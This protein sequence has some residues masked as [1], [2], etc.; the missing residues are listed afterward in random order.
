MFDFV[1][2]L[3]QGGGRLA[4]AFKDGMDI[5][6]VV[7]NLAGIDF[8]RMGFGQYEQLVFESGGTGRD[9]QYGE[10]I[11][12]ERENEFESFLMGRKAFS[13]SKRVLLTVGG[14][15][16]AGTGFMFPVL[17]YLLDRGK[18]VLL[19]YTLPE[20]REGLPTKPNALKS[21][22]RLIRDYINPERISPLLIDN[23]FCV[24]RYGRSVEGGYWGQVNAGIVNSLKRFYMLTQLEKF[25]AFI[26]VSSGYKALDFNDLT[27]MLFSKNGYIDL[28]R[29][30]FCNSSTEGLLRSIR[31]S[32]LVFGALDTKSTKQ[33][34]ISVGIPMHW[35]MHGWTAEFVESIFQAVS[36]STRYAPSVIRTSYYNSRIS[37]LQVHLL[38][39]GMARSK[40]IDTMILGIEKDQQRM[41]D[42]KGVDRLGITSV[43]K[44]SKV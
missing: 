3:G 4:K 33:Y 14:G 13:G 27:R 35:K 10:C 38:L 31:D 8:V 15:G 42:R 16:G 11:V 37:E 17:D 30:V 9:P 1:I 23:D 6:M 32:S 18:D 40:R 36:R 29:M 25:N 39:S 22:D 2:G 24:Q 12:R 26:D 21:L 41:R 19:I 44:K 5:P 20:E 7:M 34:V 28:R 43:V